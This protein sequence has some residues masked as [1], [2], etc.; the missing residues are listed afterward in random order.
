LSIAFFSSRAKQPLIKN[1]IEHHVGFMRT[2]GLI[3]NSQQIDFSLRECAQEPLR[4]PTVNGWPKHQGWLSA[5]GMLERANFLRDCNFNHAH[6]PQAGWDGADLLVTGQDSDAEVVD[7]LAWL[8]Q[9]TLESSQRQLAIDYL[10][11]DRNAGGV[12]SQPWDPT[13]AVQR[14][15]KI[16][17]LLYILGLHSTY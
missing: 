11:E 8:L 3:I 17:G 12:I 2:T 14:D 15:K 16:R 1:V 9:V 4:P 5:H 7:R 10:N 13:S 6:P